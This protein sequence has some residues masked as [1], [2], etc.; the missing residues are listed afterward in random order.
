[1]KTLLI[2]SHTYWENS[3][4]N[5]ALAKEAL[6]LDYVK[7]HNINEVYKDGKIDAEKEI[8]LLKEAEFIVFQ[9]PLFWFSTPSLMKEW[10]DVVLSQILHGENPKLLSGK[11]FGIVSTLGGAKDTYDG[12]HGYTLNE[13]LRPIY[14]AF[15]YCGATLVDEFA[16][17]SANAS[18][19]PLQEYKSYLKG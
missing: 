9:F 5:K 13:L 16:I 17:Y 8:E 2:L 7:V 19:L 15:K 18:N 11:K 10:Q 14:Y 12:H 1:M 6:G 4:V 3:K